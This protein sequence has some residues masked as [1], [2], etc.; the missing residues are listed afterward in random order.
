[1]RSTS[2]AE[3][4]ECPHFAEGV[5]QFAVQLYRPGNAREGCLMIACQAL[6][7]T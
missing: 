7:V 4:R 5:T 2:G 6:E 1:M 3:L